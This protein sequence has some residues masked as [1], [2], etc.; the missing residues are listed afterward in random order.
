[1]VISHSKKFIFIHN[2][3]VAGTNI[4]NALTPYSNKTFWKS[5][6]RDQL[7]FLFNSYPSIYSSDFQSHIT[8]A[9][10]KNSIPEEMFSSYFKFGFVRDPWD[11]QVSLYC[12]ILKMKEH[13]QHK[14]VKKMKCFDE[15][16]EWRANDDLFLQKQFFY[17]PDGECLMDYIGKFETVN[18]SMR[19][20]FD[21]FSLDIA[22]PHLNKSRD[23]A[24]YLHFYTPYSIDL[25]AE[26][27]REDLETF[28]YTKPE[29]VAAY[30]GAVS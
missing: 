19:K 21:M 22:M 4:E 5:G 12:Y 6:F 23:E 28:G 25:V 11:W 20:L 10:L 30:A 29:P 13:H 27:Y 17:S 18:A 2:Y 3:K 7:K 15:F 8:A 26:A 14:M 24:G 9:E 16:I 1:M